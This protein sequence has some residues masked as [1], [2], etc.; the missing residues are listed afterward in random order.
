MAY[1]IGPSGNSNDCPTF[2]STL[3]KW[4]S[5]TS[6][7]M[8]DWVQRRIAIHLSIRFMVGVLVRQI[9]FLGFIFC[10][11]SV[12]FQFYWLIIINASNGISRL[13]CSISIK[14]WPPDSVFAL[15]CF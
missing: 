13:Y 1:H 12:V 11:I 2:W 14:L 8:A 7:R 15:C 3:Y 4:L 5:Y 9:C 10:V 6:H